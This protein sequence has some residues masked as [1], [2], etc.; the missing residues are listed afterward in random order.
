MPLAPVELRHVRLR[1]SLLFGYSR[2]AV[3]ELLSQTAESFEEVWRERADLA[4][5]VEHL[6]HELRR[7]REI[8]SLLRET[9]VSAER[10]AQDVKEQARTEAEL[11]VREAHSAARSI[12]HEALAE[13][14]R[15][16]GDAARVR[17]LLGNALQSVDE[18]ATDTPTRHAEAA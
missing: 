5:R 16:L 10:S 6:E 13:R 8:E 12:T 3:D 1:R 11:I 2:R 17:A 4:D 9:L 7:H 15:L 18:A 14:E